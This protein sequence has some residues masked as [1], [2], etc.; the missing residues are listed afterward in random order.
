MQFFGANISFRSGL[1]PSA[2]R[3]RRQPRSLFDLEV[4]AQRVSHWL[5]SCQVRLYLRALA[6]KLPN[7]FRS[8]GRQ[9]YMRRCRSFGAD[10][11]KCK[12]RG[13]GVDVSQSLRFDVEAM[14]MRQAFAHRGQVFCH[15]IV[16]SEGLSEHSRFIDLLRSNSASSL[17]LRVA[18]SMLRKTKWVSANA[19]DRHAERIE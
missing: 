4:I 9:G 10:T 18:E 7:R 1:E 13:E 16:P 8:D 14:S 19:R 6:E 17:L 2:I 5:A 15:R 3:V 12:H 11:D